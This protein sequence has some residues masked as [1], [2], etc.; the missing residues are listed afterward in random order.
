MPKNIRIHLERYVVNTRTIDG[1]M[2]FRAGA[3]EE[4][5]AD[6]ANPST[7]TYRGTGYHRFEGW[8]EDPDTGKP[9]M[10]DPEKNARG[11][12]ALNGNSV[13][14]WTGGIPI[15]M[16]NKVVEV[17]LEEFAQSRAQVL[18]NPNR[19]NFPN[20][21]MIF[22]NF[23][24]PDD[25]LSDQMIDAQTKRKFNMDNYELGIKHE[26]LKAFRNRTR[27]NAQTGQGRAFVQRTVQTW[28]E[29]NSPEGGLSVE[30][31]TAA[32]A[33]ALADRKPVISAPPVKSVEEPPQ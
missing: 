3:D 13:E 24:L 31:A 32:A 10:V 15:L 23:E 4:S 29:Y 25:Q 8:A 11:L 20:Y 12:F 21:T 1:T 33:K 6:T 22:T 16:R 26:E 19:R 28:E 7:K 9:I 14:Y 30:E 2:S 17:T 18:S 27:S 5:S